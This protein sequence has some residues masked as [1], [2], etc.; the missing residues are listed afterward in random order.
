MGDPA[1]GCGKEFSVKFRCR[2]NALLRSVSIPPEAT[3]KTLDIDCEK[4]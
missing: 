2:Q 1:P 3:G 4:G